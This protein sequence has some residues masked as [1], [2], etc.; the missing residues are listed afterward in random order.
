MP[1][2]ELRS[3][4]HPETAEKEISAMTTERTLFPPGVDDATGRRPDDAVDRI[5][6]GDAENHFID[7]ISIGAGGI[8]ATV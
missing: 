5:A 3:H 4:R 1:A 6:V 8:A 2:P 7:I